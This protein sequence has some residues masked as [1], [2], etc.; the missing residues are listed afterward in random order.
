MVDR[1]RIFVGNDIFLWMKIFLWNF[2]EF[3]F[4]ILLIIYYFDEIIVNILKYGL[5]LEWMICKELGLNIRFCEVL[6]LFY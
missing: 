4:N 6:N 1:F 3:L 5:I 2:G